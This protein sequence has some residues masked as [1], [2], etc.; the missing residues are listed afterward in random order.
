M[1]EVANN[2]GMCRKMGC[3]N[4]TV[5]WS[6]CWVGEGDVALEFLMVETAFLMGRRDGARYDH[7]D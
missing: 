2:R 1:L 4:N 5:F 7:Y 3:G 6:G